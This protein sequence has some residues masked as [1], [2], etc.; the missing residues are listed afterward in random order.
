[1]I[2][3]RLPKNTDTNDFITVNAPPFNES[4]YCFANGFFCFAEIV[5]IIVSDDFAPT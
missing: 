4:S 2:D 3:S 1:M 5:G